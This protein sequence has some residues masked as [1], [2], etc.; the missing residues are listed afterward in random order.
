MF[1]PDPTDILD[2]EAFYDEDGYDTVNVLRVDIRTE[3]TAGTCEIDDQ[4]GCT[5]DDVIADIDGNDDFKVE[6]PIHFQS[7]DFADD[8]S[9]SNATLRQRGNTSRLGPQKSFRIKLDDRDNLWRNERRLQLNKH[10]FERTRQRNKLSFDLMQELPHLPSLRTQFVNLWIDDGNGPEDFGLFTHVEFAGREY[11]QNRNRD[12]DDPLY[13]I[14]FFQFSQGDLN[15]VQVDE[16]GEPLDEDRFEQSLS[17]ERGDDHSKLVEMLTALNDPDQSFESVFDRYFNHNNVLM[18][19]T[20][21]LLMHQTDA[22]TH[23]FYLY[24]PIDSDKFYFLPWDY[25]GTF[26]PEPVLTDGLDTDS[27]LNRL[28]YGYARGINSNFVSNY[29]RIPGIHQKI[30]AAADEIRNT[31]LTDANIT[32]KAIENDA[33]VAPFLER[34]PDGD[35]NS[36]NGNIPR[37]FADFVS[38]IHDLM[39]NAFDIPMPHSLED[40]VVETDT[41]TFAWTPAYDVTQTNV[42]DYDLQVATSTDFDADSIVLTVED[43]PDAVDLVEYEADITQLP[44]GRLYYRVIARGDTDPARVWQVAEN[45][46]RTAGTTFYGM[47]EFDIP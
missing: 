39:H 32:A 10:P 15:N 43:I 38:S 26:H 42:L 4:S 13:K 8:G 33:L 37:A 16:D 2:V 28:F 40:V 18:W 36:H 47:V 46:L 7:E 44:S 3:T 11:L 5:L 34:S 30:L 41:V 6:I 29:Y 25:D 45:R 31:W 14:E 20:A 27:I 21:N 35:F 22:I 23:N 12:K 9:T 17:I 24:N 19:V 1:V